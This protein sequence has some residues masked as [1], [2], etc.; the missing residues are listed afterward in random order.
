MEIRFEGDSSEL[1]QAG[2]K[3]GMGGDPGDNQKPPG[4][5]A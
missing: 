2:T 5:E 3:S 1:I 4:Q